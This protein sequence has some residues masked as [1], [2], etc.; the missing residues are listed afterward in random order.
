MLTQAFY[1]GISGLRTHQSAIDIT[2]DNLANVNTVGYRGYNTEFASLLESSI[3][4][5][6][7]NPSNSIGVG[8]R[9]QTTNM[10]Q[11]V[12]TKLLSDRNTDIAIEG[13]GWFGVTNDTNTQYTRAGNFTFDSNNDLVTTDGFYLLGTKSGNISGDKL[14]SVIDETQLGNLNSQ[15]KLRFPKSL[16]YPA[17]PTTKAEF[18]GNLG[19]ENTPRR[20]SATAIDSQNN[21]N[22]LQLLFTKSEP[23]VLPGIQWDVVAATKSLDD[24]TTYDTKTGKL[25]FNEDGALLS[26]TL[27]TIDNNGT[28]INIDLG[29][30]YEGIVVTNS[31]VSNSST[32]NGTIGGDLVGYEINRKAEVIATF[33][34]GEQ[35]SVGKIALYHF[36]NDAGLQRVSGT[37]FEQSSNS[38]NAIFFQDENGQNILGTTVNNFTLENSNIRLENALTE[39]IILQRAFD[40]NSKTISAADQMMQKALQMD[41]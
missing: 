35:S 18:F 10:T 2:A 28:N 27:T 23:Q 24:S 32:T 13:D 37:R 3:N 33:T 21:K 6:A 7:T 11:D 29:S 9:L 34:N 16:S 8:S 12:G 25:E 40:A 22:N 38:G 4:T 41:A 5:T 17:E 31:T 20:I 36:Q 15:E 1:T 30:G 19:L 26:N 14:T 39:L